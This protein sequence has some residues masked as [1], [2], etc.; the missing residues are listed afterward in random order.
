MINKSRLC[1][2]G[3][4]YVGL[5][6]AIEFS[7]HYLT[8]G[9]DTNKL[10]IENLKK[11]KDINNEI[12][13]T[14]LKKSKI[15]FTSKEKDL[16]NCNIYIVTVPTPIKKN[17]LPDLRILKKATKLISKYLKHKDLVIY[18]STVYP[19]VTDDVCIPIL[20]EFSG[21]K[22]KNNKINPNRSN[23]FYCGYSPERMNPG[24]K[25][26][27]LSKIPKLVSS[28]DNYSLNLVF[29]LYK[30]II[31]EKVIK[32]DQIRIAEAAKIIENIQRDV[33]VALVNELSIIFDKLNIPTSKVL[34]AASTKWNFNKY[35]PGLVGG[36]CIG[37]DPYYLAYIAKVKKIFPKM[38]L[39]GR[40]INN[41][42]PKFI[43]SKL[44][45]LMKE[46]LIQ[47]QSSKILI[48]GFTFKENCSDF[49]NTLVFDMYNL[50]NKFTKKVDIYDPYVNTTD[51]KKVYNIKIKTNLINQRYDCII[52]A[53]KHNIFKKLD[54]NKN[55]SKIIKQKNIVIDLKDF[56]KNIKV[57]Y[58]L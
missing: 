16:K 3:L 15:K 22:I 5:P 40:Q 34:Y 41:N 38:I 45:N 12:S 7:K 20:E 4:G 23:Y 24:D 44:K 56:F 2:I 14:I 30:K 46:K 58:K 13:S 19:G 42:M 1:I 31:N 21:L 18:E 52:L 10:R 55:I 8:F 36:H 37:V 27:T 25:I 48:L 32:I 26:R 35:E 50:I 6:L 39:S 9:Y 29:N 49:R 28:N 47:T 17:N 43:S 11:N 57:D 53:V 51:V 54:N 33:N